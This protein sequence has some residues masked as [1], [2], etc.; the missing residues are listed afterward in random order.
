[1]ELWHRFPCALLTTTLSRGSE[2]E[3]CL[4]VAK[5]RKVPRCGDLPGSASAPAHA[6]IKE[7]SRAHLSTIET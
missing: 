2:L 1:M 7:P 3:Q 5:R 4:C 6:D